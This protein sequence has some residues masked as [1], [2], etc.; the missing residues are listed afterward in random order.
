MRQIVLAQAVRTR[1][2]AEKLGIARPT[3]STILSGGK[4]NT[5]VSDDLRERVLA[6]AK[7]MGYRPNAA[8]KAIG[9]G[10]FGS[11]GLVLSAADPGRSSVPS[12]LLFGTSVELEKHGMHLSVA[13]LDDRQLTDESFMPRVL[14]ESA[15]DGLLI[16]YHKLIPARMIELIEDY[17][18]PSIWLNIKRKHDCVYFDDFGAGRRATQMLI[19]AGHHRIAFASHHWEGKDA[20]YSEHDRRDGYLRAMQQTGLTSEVVERIKFGDASLP[21]RLIDYWTERLGRAD[22]PT[23]VVA[24]GSTALAPIVRAGDRL[25]LS[26]P[27][28]LSVVTFGPSTHHQA[29][30][31]DTMVHDEA[32]MGRVAIERLLWKIR[33]PRSRFAPEVL[34]MDWRSVGSVQRRNPR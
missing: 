20:H 23:G 30:S 31:L 1:D 19:N 34:E 25:G 10:R 11:V 9:T 14:R 26:I 4:S 24:Y 3:V 15:V 21:N 33:S 32:E 12:Q 13:A 18:I 2:I 28:D 27:A 5:R 8:A 7:Q 6:T 22:R 29:M 16:N 17:R